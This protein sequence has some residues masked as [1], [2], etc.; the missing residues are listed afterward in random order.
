M[1]INALEIKNFRKFKSQFFGFHPQFNVLIG[2]NAKGKTQLL[3][4]ISII[5]CV[6]QSKLLCESQRGIKTEEVRVEERSVSDKGGNVQNRRA[7]CYPVEIRACLTYDDKNFEQSCVKTEK[8]RTTFGKDLAFA[9]RAKKDYESIASGKSIDLPFLGYYGVGRL[10][11]I[12]KHSGDPESVEYTTDG[13]VDSLDP[14]NESK[15]FKVGS[16]DVN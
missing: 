14:R 5:W 7:S 16:N 6:Y 15:R 8:G 10:A 11:P 12:L 9:Q 1:R 4:A 13:Y 2:D 3:D